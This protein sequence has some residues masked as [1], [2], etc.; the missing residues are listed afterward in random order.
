MY[1]TIIDIFVWERASGSVT[2]LCFR[3]NIFTSGVFEFM[4]ARDR[5]L[6]YGSEGFIVVFRDVA[7]CRLVYT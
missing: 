2:Y 5:I 7:S 1:I 4:Q 6:G 3:I